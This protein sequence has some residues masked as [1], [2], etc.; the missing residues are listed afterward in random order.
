MAGSSVGEAKRTIAQAAEYTAKTGEGIKA[1]SD[2]LEEAQRLVHAAAGD[3][4]HE[5]MQDS[6]QKFKDAR[7]ALIDAERLVREAQEAANAY[8]EAIG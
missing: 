7:D 8:A 1:A 4:S 5:L 6:V 3:V 2:A